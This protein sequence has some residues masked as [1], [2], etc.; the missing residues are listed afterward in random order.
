MNCP[1]KGVFTTCF[2]CDFF[3]LSVRKK[4]PKKPKKK[5]KILRQKPKQKSAF[6]LKRPPPFSRPANKPKPK[7]KPKPVPKQKLK[8]LPKSQLKPKTK[9][10]PQNQRPPHLKPDSSGAAPASGTSRPKP[11]IQSRLKPKSRRNISPKQSPP[12]ARPPQ[13]KSKLKLHL[14]SK[15]RRTLSQHQS[16]VSRNKSQFSV[17]SVW[18]ASVQAAIRVGDWKLLTGDPGH[19]DWV[20]PQ[21]LC[22]DVKGTVWIF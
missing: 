15:F 4:G 19:G 8:P 12:W 1:F 21:V 2:L 6:K 5:K 14:K 18:D 17:P 10:S 9:D 20:P 7:P 13:P 16:N 3:D 22:T 11:H